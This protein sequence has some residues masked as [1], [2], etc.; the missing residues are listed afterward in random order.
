[1]KPGRDTKLEYAQIDGEGW[2]WSELPMLFTEHKGAK[3]IIPAGFMTDG[4][5][6]PKVFQSFFSK[7]G[8]YLM[9]A[10]LHDWL[11]KAGCPQSMPRKEV[12]RLFLHYMKL[13]G[14]GWLTR[15]SIYT[16]VR[17]GGW[18]SWRKIKAEFTPIT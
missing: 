3:I 7:T 8:I 18:G 13:Y 2:Y 15:R 17:I 9:P 16:A 6:I 4:A 1:M 12:D 10:I 5:S 11:Y 14:V